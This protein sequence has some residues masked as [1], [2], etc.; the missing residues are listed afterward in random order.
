MAPAIAGVLETCLYVDDMARARAFYQDVLGLDPMVSEDRLTVYDAGPA[1]ALI[2]FQ[3]GGTLDTV[4]LPGGT[5]PP[6]DGRGPLHFALAIPAD[7]LDGWRRHLADAGVALEGEM[8]WK[9]GGTS[10]YFRDP[11]GH[12]VEL[13]TPGLWRNYR[14]APAPSSIPW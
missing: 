5:I 7:S 13:A 8:K 2:L 10:L 3:R 4:R 9:A 11:E 14:A 12:L 1:M 6:H